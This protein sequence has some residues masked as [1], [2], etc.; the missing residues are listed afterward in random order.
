MNKSCFD[1]DII[2]GIF[3]PATRGNYN[4]CG[5]LVQQGYINYNDCQ[6]TYYYPD[7]SIVARKDWD[8]CSSRNISPNEVTSCLQNVIN[9]YCEDL[10]GNSP[11]GC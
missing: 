3:N 2:D 11:S 7:K 5:F 4:Q 1:Q 6:K 9:E 8:N 10:G